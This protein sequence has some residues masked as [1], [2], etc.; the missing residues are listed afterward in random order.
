MPVSKSI[1]LYCKSNFAVNT[2]VNTSCLVELESHLQSCQEFGGDNVLT[3]IMFRLPFSHYL[4]SR[5]QKAG[6]CK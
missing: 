6:Q 4:P 1:Q 2:E 3:M 5:R